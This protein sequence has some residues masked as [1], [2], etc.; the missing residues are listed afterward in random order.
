VDNLE[1]EGIASTEDEEIGTRGVV[2]PVFTAAG[3]QNRVGTMSQICS[4]ADLE[5]DES[6]GSETEFEVR[7]GLKIGGINSVVMLSEEEEAGRAS[8][9]VDVCLETVGE[10]EEVRVTC[11]T[12]VM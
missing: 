6:S 3:V 10:P 12:G 7:M 2:C 4:D 11:F 9:E 1:F 8:S 5:K